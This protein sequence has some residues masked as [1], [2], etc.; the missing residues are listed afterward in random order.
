MPP[1]RK[2]TNFA[3]WKKPVEVE[4]L[5]VTQRR[6]GG[7]AYRDVYVGRL[8]FGG[9]AASKARRVA[10]K[11]FVKPLSKT[12]AAEYQRAIKKLAG[13]GVP[14]P[15]MGIVRHN[16]KWVLVSQL[17]L[18]GGKSRLRQMG[19]PP[20]KKQAIRCAEI[21][22]RVINAG[23]CP[24]SDLFELMKRGETERRA[25][26]IPLDLDIVVRERRSSVDSKIEYAVQ[27]IVSEIEEKKADRRALEGFVRELKPEY[28]RKAR[29]IISRMA[30]Q[31][32][33]F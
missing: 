19:W 21:S 20:T 24:S 14:L 11:S 1:A 6:I 2:K 27:E 5:S 10:V 3:A 16:G 4:R 15:K 8:R 28:R 30:A 12:M 31:R 25:L 22:A 32:K 29:A 9:E 7:E 26:A 17:F 33:Q 18:R 23:Y 13:A